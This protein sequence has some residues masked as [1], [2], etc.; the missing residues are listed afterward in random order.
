MA[1]FIF[2]IPKLDESSNNL[3]VNEALLHL[4]RFEK[5]FIIQSSSSSLVL[6][7]KIKTIENSRSNTIPGF[8]N[9]AILSI[10][11]EN[12]DAHNTFVC[13]LNPKMLERII[14]HNF[15][16]FKDT[17][18]NDYL[19]NEDNNIHPDLFQFHTQPTNEQI[20]FHNN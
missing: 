20:K 19:I 10:L 3:H 9:S 17:N 4:S 14:D 2:L 16:Y 1:Q 8:L 11:S 13:Y 15:I 5:T 6:N 7:E 18:I 12:L